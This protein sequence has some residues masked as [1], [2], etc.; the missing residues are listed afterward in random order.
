M[1]EHHAMTARALSFGY[2][3]RATKDFPSCPRKLGTGRH[4]GA[5]CWCYSRLN[6]H[7]GAWTR[8]GEKVVLW[9][10]Y[11]IS[12]VE[13]VRVEQL[14]VRDGLWVHVHARSPHYPGATVAIEF[15]VRA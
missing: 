5:S 9:Q 8:H 7:G 3:P 6:D 1:N 13:L 14:A 15:G 11:E 12:P 4:A 10:P 2:S